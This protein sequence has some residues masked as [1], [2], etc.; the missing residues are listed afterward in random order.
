MYSFYFHTLS[1][2][3]NVCV[4]ARQLP[5]MAAAKIKP[6]AWILQL[7]HEK[8]DTLLKLTVLTTAAI[9]CKLHFDFKVVCFLLFSVVIHIVNNVSFLL[10]FAIRLFSVLRF[11]SV[12]HE[13]DPYFNYRTTNYLAEEGFYNFHN[14]FDD[15]AWYPLGRIIGGT[16]Y[17]GA[18]TNVYES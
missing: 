2:I 1:L 6:V 9:L 10:A 15:R 7:S 16:I 4:A 3:R 8:Q 11:E 5:N 17:P 14:W 13:F 18:F 12:I